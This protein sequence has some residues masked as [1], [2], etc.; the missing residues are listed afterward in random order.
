MTHTSIP[1]RAHTSRAR[2][3]RI[4]TFPGRHFRLAMGAALALACALAGCNAPGKTPDTS[5]AGAS[6]SSAAPA[7]AGQHPANNSGTGSN[8]SARSRVASTELSASW[9][10]KNF[11]DFYTQDIS[12]RPCTEADGLSEELAALATQ[13]GT[14]VSTFQCGTVKAPL[15]WA[16][17]GDTR[18]VELAVSKIPTR[19]GQEKPKVMFTNPGGPGIG[20]VQHSMVMATSPAFAS[21]LEDY[22]LWGFDPRGIGNSTAVRCESDS[23]LAAVQL[24]ECAESSPLAHFM[25]T[26]YVARDL[27]M[28]RAISGAPELNYLGYSYGTVLGATYATLFPEKAGR[29]VLDS[30]Q[31]SAWAGLRALYDQ[32]LAVASAVGKLADSCGQL[33]TLEG[34]AVTCPF[35]SEREMLDFKKSLEATPLVASDGTA[36]HGA[37]LQSYLTSA[38][39]GDRASALDLLG[40]ARQGDVAAR[41]EVVAKAAEPGSEID[42]AGQLVV[43]PSAEKTPDVAGLLAYMEENEIPEFYGGKPARD[44]ILGELTEFECA[45]LPETGTDITDTFDASQVSN[46]VLVIGITGDH[47]TPYKYAEELRTQLGQARLLTVAGSGHGASYSDLSTCADTVAT[48]YLRRGELPAEGTVCPADQ[49]SSAQG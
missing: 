13:S 23:K 8:T 20:G 1:S 7:A 34:E 44:K 29:M 30:A 22:E 6:Q 4:R 2:T 26:S 46:P 11:A 39:Y 33:T 3:S 21:V 31:A 24:A 10:E 48:N 25:G 41:D 32:K 43:C 9:Q 15:N 45:V 36:M 37:E 47:A 18:T 5:A 38:L 49:P 42:T 12:W 28:L 16:D 35:T 17:P 27:E 40:K 19:G 14:D